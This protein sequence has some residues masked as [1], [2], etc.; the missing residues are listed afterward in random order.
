[1]EEAHLEAIVAKHDLDHRAVVQNKTEYKPAAITGIYFLLRASEVVFVGQSA[2]V[3][4][5]INHHWAEKE[6]AF[7]AYYVIECPV[8]ELNLVQAHFIC[9][10]KPVYNTALPS[11]EMFKSLN[12][13]KGVLSVDLRELKKFIRRNGIE[14]H[15]GFYKV[16]DFAE[17]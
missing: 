12:Q 3:L 17:L 7:D 11:Q 8:D 15:N 13:L 4:V 2:D 10:F 16:S 14:D 5:R 9:K 6:K 1:M